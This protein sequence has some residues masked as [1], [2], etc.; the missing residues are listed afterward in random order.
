M[1]IDSYTTNSDD[2]V[3]YFGV[4]FVIL[5]VDFRLWGHR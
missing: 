4:I 3:G 2:V 5:Y 1:L